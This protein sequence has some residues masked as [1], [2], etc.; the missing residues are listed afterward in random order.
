MFIFKTVFYVVFLLSECVCLFPL[1][2]LSSYDINCT[3]S[4]PPFLPKGHLFVHYLRVDPFSLPMLF[5]LDPF[6]WVN[7]SEMGKFAYSF[8]LI[9][10]ILNA[11]FLTGPTG[12][13]CV[14]RLFLLSS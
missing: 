7:K 5:H 2:K 3:F 8:A 11:L 13:V 6:W 1:E 9:I 4:L 14:Y 12:E 10:P